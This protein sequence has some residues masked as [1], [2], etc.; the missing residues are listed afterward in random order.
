MNCI[1]HFFSRT[2]S[3]KGRKRLDNAYLASKVPII[4]GRHMV[5][6]LSDYRVRTRL[7]KAVSFPDDLARHT[8]T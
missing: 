8:H 1:G 7:K 6:G 5:V 2:S 4:V 3:H